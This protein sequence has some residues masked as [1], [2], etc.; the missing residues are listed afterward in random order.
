MATTAWAGATVA[1]PICLAASPY[2]ARLTL[3]VADRGNATWYGGVPVSRRR[4]VVTAGVALVVGA[5]AGAAAGLSTLL[6]A[7]IVL[8][9]TGTPLVVIDHEQHRLPNRLV[10]PLAAGAIVLL[11]AAAASRDDWSDLLRAGEGGAAVF[12]V[13]Y[14][15]MLVSPRSFGYGDARLGGILG[16]YLGFDSWAAVYCGIFLGFVLGAGLAAALLA[17]RRASRKTA[18]AFGPMLMLGTLLVLAFDL[19]PSLTA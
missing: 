10:Y 9:L 14:A 2:L 16:L 1:I 19:T 3:T 11:F 12:A 18:I 15:I 8:A 4:Q 7:F 5:L 17:A 6:P 13:L